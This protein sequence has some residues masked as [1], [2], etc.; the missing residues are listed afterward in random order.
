MTPFTRT[1]ALGRPT[2][3][4]LLLAKGY[5]YFG[6][7]PPYTP[8]TPLLPPE[9]TEDNTWHTLSTTDGEFTVDMLWLAGMWWP[10]TGQGMRLAFP[11]DYLGSLG[12]TYGGTL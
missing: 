6:P 7:L 11:P 8:G 3:F 2:E 10:T 12:W 1:V 5:F 9:G 4:R